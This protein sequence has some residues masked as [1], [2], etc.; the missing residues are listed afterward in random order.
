MRRRSCISDS[1]RVSRSAQYSRTASFK[2]SEGWKLSDPS[3]TQARAP[4]T[5]VPMPGTNGSIISAEA[6]IRPGT[7]SRLQNV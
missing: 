2:N 1:R 7:T 5:S 6:P 3:D 4:L